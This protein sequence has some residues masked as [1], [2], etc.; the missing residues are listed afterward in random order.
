MK[1]KRKLNRER[2]CDYDEE[3]SKKTKK[4]VWERK[5]EEVIEKYVKGRKQDEIKRETKTNKEY[6]K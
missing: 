2:L 3:R 1:R 4:L 6:S 5:T